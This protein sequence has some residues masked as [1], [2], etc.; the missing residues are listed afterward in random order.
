M[1]AVMM[2]TLMVVLI[3]SDDGLLSSGRCAKTFG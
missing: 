1:L 3:V 2:V